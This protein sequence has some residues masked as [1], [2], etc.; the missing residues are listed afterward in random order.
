MDAPD[1]TTGTEA[2]DAMARELRDL[3][4]AGRYPDAFALAEHGLPPAARRPDLRLL[5]ATA[6]TRVGQAER[7]AALAGEALAG[8]EGRADADGRLRAI[9]LLGA[10]A[11]ERGDPVEAERRFTEALALGRQLSDTQMAA[12]AANNLASL[13][14]LRGELERALDLYRAALVSYQRLGDRRGLAETWHNLALVFRQAGDYARAD[15]AGAQAVHHAER[16]ADPSLLALAVMG[17][18][19]LD[20][21][22]DEFELAGSRLDR[23]A[24][25]AA[26]AADQPGQLEV[27]YLRA[28][29]ALREGRLEDASRL[30]EAALQTAEEMGSALLAAECAGVLALARKRVGDPAAADAWRGRALAGFDRLGA[31]NVRARFE[32]EWRR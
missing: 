13:L 27:S 16:V 31:G 20:L 21:E 8:F 32:Q 12:R 30:A 22:R 10:Q 28:V 24:R 5:A 25:L 6:A 14:H 23:A 7:G 15:D 29:L 2:A 3:L 17:R 18:A 9:N 26:A 1:P 4:A 11:F 19:E